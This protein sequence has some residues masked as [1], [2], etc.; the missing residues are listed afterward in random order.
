MHK[1]FIR[2]IE[3]K[4]L[5]WE[6]E[7]A[8]YGDQSINDY[9]LPIKCGWTLGK[10]ENLKTDIP[11]LLNQKEYAEKIEYSWDYERPIDIIQTP[12]SE[13]QRQAEMDVILYDYFV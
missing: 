12:G 4:D 1:K 10:F 8:M 13:W 9:R 7:Y 3:R 5:R 2:S 11:M 6:Y